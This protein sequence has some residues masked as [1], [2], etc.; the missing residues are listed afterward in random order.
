[1]VDILAGFRFSEKW[2]DRVASHAGLGMVLTV[3]PI[4]STQEVSFHGADVR[5][6]NRSNR[7][8]V[9]HIRV[10]YPG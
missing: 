1:M 5:K 8:I 3:K 4:G 7:L 6:I 2:M 10:G 9:E